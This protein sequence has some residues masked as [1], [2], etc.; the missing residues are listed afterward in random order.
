M[1]TEIEIMAAMRDYR[2]GTMGI[3]VEE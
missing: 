1:N 3:L 2:M